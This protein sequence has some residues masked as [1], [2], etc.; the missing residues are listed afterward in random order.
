MV[1]FQIFGVFVETGFNVDD[2]PSAA[3]NFVFVFR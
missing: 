2:L 3:L 1:L